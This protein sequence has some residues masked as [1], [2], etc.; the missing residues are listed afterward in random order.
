[1]RS[2][3]FP[4]RLRTSVV[5]LLALALS[6][7]LSPGESSAQIAAPLE[8]R[9]WRAAIAGGAS[10]FWGAEG[11]TVGYLFETGVLR[12]VRNTPFSLR[13]D[14]MIHHYDAQDVA[15]CLV[16]VGQTCFPLMQ[17]SIGGVALGAQYTLRQSSNASS[18]APYLLGGLATYFSSRVASRPPSCSPGELCANVTERR[19]INDIDYGVQVGAGTSWPVGKRELYLE[20]KYHHRI[21]R[22]HRDDPFTSFRFSPIAVG[23]RF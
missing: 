12:R 5:G 2:S 13:G 8:D 21:I 6:G 4:S 19:T 17:R 18:A 9:P 3:A 7:P 15:P 23:I 14:V 16:A 20:S 11:N 22:S 10:F 1:M